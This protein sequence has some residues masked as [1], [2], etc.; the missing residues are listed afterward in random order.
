M[1]AIR[2]PN[3]TLRRPTRNSRSLHHVPDAA[4]PSRQPWPLPLS[5]AT[6]GSAAI[7]RARP[8][9]PAA[10]MQPADANGVQTLTTTT[11]TADTATCKRDPYAARRAAIVRSSPS[12][13]IP[14]LTLLKMRAGLNGPLGRENNTVMTTGVVERHHLRPEHR[15][16]RHAADPRPGHDGCCS[17][18]T[19]TSTTTDHDDPRRRMRLVE[20]GP[21][22]G[23]RARAGRRK[24]APVQP[25]P[26]PKADRITDRCRQLKTK[27][28]AGCPFFGR[29]RRAGAFDA[30]AFCAQAVI[31]LSVC[32]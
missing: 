15:R 2:D 32:R 18:T 11:T 8:R 4:S 14:R 28:Q 7:D 10:R 5:L 31:R 25:M 27:R 29:G 21:G 9:P 3:Q 13:A 24:P 19:G 17:V 16:P 22:A 26:A 12:P 30:T 1:K 6:V 23:R 20:A